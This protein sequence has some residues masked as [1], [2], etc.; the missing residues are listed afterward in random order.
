MKQKICL[1]TFFYNPAV[2]RPDAIRDSAGELREEALFTGIGECVAKGGV[3]H[4]SHLEADLVRLT[5]GPNEPA[6]A[7]E[8][9]GLV[10][11]P[12]QP[13][14]K[15]TIILEEVADAYQIYI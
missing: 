9:V 10:F 1:M 8:W 7:H 15:E 4:I 11:V 2:T 12:V 5:G 13:A 3:V 14:A 6:P